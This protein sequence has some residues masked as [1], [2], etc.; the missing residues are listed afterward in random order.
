MKFLHSIL[1]CIPTLL[2]A[3]SFHRDEEFV[4]NLPAYASRTV[5]QPCDDANLVNRIVAAY[6]KAEKKHLGNSMWQVVFD[7]RLTPIHHVFQMG[8]IV[9]ASTVL[10]NPGHTDLFWGI[11]NLCRSVLPNYLSYDGLTA[12]ATHSLDSLVRFGE[13]IGAIKLD[14]VENHQSGLL[15]KWY[16]NEVLDSIEA[17]LGITINFPNPFPDELGIFTKKGTASGKAIQALYQAYLIKELLKDIPNPRVLEI[18]AGLGRTAYYCKQ[19]GIENYII[20]DIPI[21]ALASSYFLGR[22][23]GED[24]IALLGENLDNSERKI[25]I[26]TPD[27]FLND[28]SHYDLIINVDSLTEMDINTI[29]LYLGKIEKTCPMFLSINHEENQYSVFELLSTSQRVKTVQRKPYWMRLGYVEELYT[30]DLPKKSDIP[31]MQSPVE[32]G[33]E[34]HQDVPSSLQ[35]AEELLTPV[36]QKKSE[37]NTIQNNPEQPSVMLQ[38]KPSLSPQQ[39]AGLAPQRRGRSITPK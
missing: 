9:E 14:N 36:A 20:I 19:F 31:D 35:K 11:D 32:Q 5:A 29:K 13:A 17:K 4:K 37:V 8:N 38:D 2:C 39:P 6:Q 30:F 7:E 15:R 22:T 1:F 25:K 10:R 28:E 26:L 21:T 23:V 12:T 18:G 27:Q 33:K 3:A 34:T 16:A 24:Q